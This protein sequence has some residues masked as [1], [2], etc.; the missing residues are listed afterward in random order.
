M[1]YRR[2]GIVKS[3]YFA[4]THTT[5]WVAGTTYG[6]ATMGGIYASIYTWSKR[7]V[8]K[9]VEGVPYF[10]FLSMDNTGVL[11]ITPETVTSGGTIRVN[12]LYI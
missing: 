8:Y 4:G 12:E 9:V 10:A 1:W 2:Y 5:T 11:T 6:L 3:V 7:I